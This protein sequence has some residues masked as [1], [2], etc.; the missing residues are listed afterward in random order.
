MSNHEDLRELSALAA[1]GQLSSDE[2]RELNAHL[3]ECPECREA[4]ADYARVVRHQLPQADS[5]RWRVKSAINAPAADVQVR[6][7]FLARAR[8]EG[9]EI[10]LSAEKS[11]TAPS[12]RS[13]WRPSPKGLTWSL[14]TVCAVALFAGGLS[15]KYELVPRSNE[16]NVVQEQAGPKTQGL[17][18][19]LAE[20]QRILNLKTTE[21]EHLN[22]GKSASDE[23][24]RTLQK[25]IEQARSQA[26]KLSAAL[27]QA[28]SANTGLS[29]ANQLKDATIADLQAQNDKL[30]NESADRLAD[31]VVLETQVRNLTA[32]LQEETANVER[33]R[34]LSAV[35]Q[36]VRRLM[37]ARN[38]HVIDVHDVDGGGK[39]AKSF[40]R[41]FYAQDQSLIF[42]AF[43]LPNGKLTPAK[44]TFQ[45][46]GQ[47]EYVS[48]S[49]RNL[50]TFEVDDH[51]QRRWVLKVND[52]A[53]LRDIDSVFVTAESPTDT[54][55]PH[56]RKL[57]YAYIVGQPN[58]P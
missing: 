35:A 53:L 23:S 11:V 44:Y 45:A 34:E 10:S 46:W 7:R 32:S 33:E 48:G 39:S 16:T 30:A 25:E 14:A 47:R 19:G 31:R 5:V 27:Q 51:E 12:S 36:D 29:G 21:L 8:A 26:D 58:H 18:E 42:Y 2:D 24:L 54:K 49:V 50:G 13:S 52:P 56:G 4:H 38:L 1:V 3:R 22:R 28:E 20:L 9:I 37:G 17:T 43:D 57:L 41:V 55:E 15:R 6:D 40:G